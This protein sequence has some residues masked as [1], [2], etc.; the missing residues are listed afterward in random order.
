MERKAYEIVVEEGKFFYKNSGEMLQTS[1][2]EESDSKWIFVLSTS[3]VLYIGKKKKG[4]FQHS[5]C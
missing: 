2:M 5:S 1:S 4:V 3:K